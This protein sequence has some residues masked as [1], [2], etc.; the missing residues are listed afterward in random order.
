MPFGQNL[1]IAEF[2]QGGSFLNKLPSWIPFGKS[3]QH[4]WRYYVTIP[5]RFMTDPV[6]EDL[7][8]SN[9]FMPIIRSYHSKSISIPHYSYDGNY[10]QSYGPVPRSF[11]VLKEDGF[12]IRME[13]EE[14]KHGTIGNFIN[15]LERA[16]IDSKTGLYRAPDAY[17]IPSILVITENENAIPICIYSL[18][19]AF[20]LSAEKNS[21]F[22]YSNNSQ[23]IY[24][25]TFKVDI[26]NTFFPQIQAI[27]GAANLLPKIIQI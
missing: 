9:G 2:F 27:Y 14:D 24:I 7:Y 18:S 16:P 5:P 23:L 3:I 12:E 13:L 1:E 22:D 25:V 6:V 19:N 20:Y 26:I 10:Q 21:T 17:K 11:A 15:W 4:T 8:N